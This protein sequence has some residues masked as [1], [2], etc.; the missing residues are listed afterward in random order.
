MSRKRPDK[1]SDR[2]LHRVVKRVLPLVPT[3]RAVT[4]ADFERMLGEVMASV[5]QKTGVSGERLRQARDK[6]LADL[7]NE[8]GRLPERQKSWPVL[9]GYLYSRF[10]GE[11]R[12]AGTETG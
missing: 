11:L 1:R 8:Y 4:K 3:D 2:E 10:L 6:V 7:P 5:V 9:I 12:E